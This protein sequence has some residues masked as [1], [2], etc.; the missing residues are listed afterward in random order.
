MWKM[1]R[2]IVAI[3]GGSSTTRKRTRKP[4]KIQQS[5]QDSERKRVREP[6]SFSTHE[7]E[8]PAP[9]KHIFFLF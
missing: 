8:P 9:Y 7:E 3:P 2:G 1:P 6:T 4:Y 5:K